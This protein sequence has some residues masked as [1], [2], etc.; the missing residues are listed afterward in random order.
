MSVQHSELYSS[1]LLH[2]KNKR[3]AACLLKSTCSSLKETKLKRSNVPIDADADADFSEKLKCIE[4]LMWTLLNPTESA[5]NYQNIEWCKWIIAG[6][7]FPEEFA[8]KGAL[9]FKN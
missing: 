7:D 6:G 1:I 9:L 2:K 3:E 4:D 8:K 5:D